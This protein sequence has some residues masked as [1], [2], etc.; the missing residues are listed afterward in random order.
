MIDF[1]EFEV[2]FVTGSQHLYGEEAL[3]QVDEDSKKIVEALG[4][5]VWKPTRPITA[6]A[7][8]PGC[9]PSLPPKCGLPG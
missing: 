1:K 4:K 3:K 8:S 2:W 9:V 6:S 7:L 5:S